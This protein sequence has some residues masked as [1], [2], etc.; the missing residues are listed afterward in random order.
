MIRVIKRSLLDDL[1]AEVSARPAVNGILDVVME[2]CIRR[3]R[4]NV[5]WG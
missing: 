3:V 2:R 1:V 4:I 5:V